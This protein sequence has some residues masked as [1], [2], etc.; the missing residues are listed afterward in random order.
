MLDSTVRVAR[1]SAEE[2]LRVIAEPKIDI[3]AQ[4]EAATVVQEESPA[5]RRRNFERAV[6][7]AASVLALTRKK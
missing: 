7:T 5:Y 1:V 6:S 4:A 3:G 2:M